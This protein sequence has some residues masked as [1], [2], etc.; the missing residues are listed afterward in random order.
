MKR[1]FLLLSIL[2]MSLMSVTVSSQTGAPDAQDT[3][4][5]GLPGD[6]LSL[7]PVLDLFQKSKTIEDFEKSLNLKE[8]GINDL[9]LDLNDTV[10]FIKVETKQKDSD[11]TFVL[12]VDVSKTEVQDVA[13]ILLSKDKEGKVTL[14]IVGD[15]DLMGK[16][17]SLNLHLR[18]L[19]S[20]LI[21]RM[22]GPSLFLQPL[23]QQH[24]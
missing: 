22:P 6:N 20:H 17:M 9:D 3:T 8:T 10:D 19:P 2:I 16:I 11:F 21:P 13:V 23:R 1:S 7:Y 12:Q 4:L 5:L 18:H 24:K 14:Q 15:K